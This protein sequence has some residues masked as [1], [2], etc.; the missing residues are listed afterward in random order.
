M[1]T[2]KQPMM[3]LPANGMLFAPP[4]PKPKQYPNH[5]MIK[6]KWTPEEDKKLTEAVE[7]Y[8]TNNW[9][10][11]ASKVIGRTGKQCRERWTGQVC[12]TISKVSWTQEEDILLFQYQRVFGNKWAKI[13]QFLPNR[14]P[15]SVKNRWNWYQRHQ[16]S[17]IIQQSLVTPFAMPVSL[18]SPITESPPPTVEKMKFEPISSIE[19]NIFG[20]GFEDFKTRMFG[21]LAC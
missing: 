4:K 5:K 12:P 11:I 6:T 7:E 17:Q 18:S 8:G 21:G 16:N 9:T 2:A 19:N 14:S 1:M 3:L 13:A 10:L 20:Q 15:I